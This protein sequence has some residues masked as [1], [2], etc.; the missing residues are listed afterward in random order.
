M[1]DTPKQP[2][3]LLRRALFGL[4]LGAVASALLPAKDAEAAVIVVRRPRRRR[5]WRRRVIIVR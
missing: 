4:A 2:S 1:E 5:P 3:P